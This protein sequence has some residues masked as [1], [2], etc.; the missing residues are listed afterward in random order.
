MTR[1]ICGSASSDT[2]YMIKDP[3]VTETLR[4]RRLR[5]MLKDVG[6]SASHV[7][8]RGHMISGEDAMA[9]SAEP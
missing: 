5:A 9:A 7:F 1:P 2:L 3:D 4:Q 6:V 8:D